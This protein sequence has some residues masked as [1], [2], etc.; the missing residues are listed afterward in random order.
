MTMVTAALQEYPAL[1]LYSVPG[2]PQ[3]WDEIVTHSQGKL[4]GTRAE[5]IAA[6]QKRIEKYTTQGDLAPR[7][8]ILKYLR[9]RD[10]RVPESA[11]TNPRNKTC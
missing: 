6:E 11:T 3:P 5:L 2:A 1:K 4:R 9:A 10:D 8:A 7:A